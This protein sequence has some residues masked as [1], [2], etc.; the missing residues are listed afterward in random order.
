MIY[1]YPLPV[2]EDHL[3]FGYGAMGSISLLPH[4]T[5]QISLELVSSSCVY[6]VHK[7]IHAHLCEQ[8]RFVLLLHLMIEGL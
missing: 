5:T 7:V 1:C 8:D 2:Q 6:S 3:F 4:N